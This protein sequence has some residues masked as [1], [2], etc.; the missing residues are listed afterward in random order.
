MCYIVDNL[1]ARET[2]RVVEQQSR[3]HE[4]GLGREC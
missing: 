4:G 3:V 2:H 1:E